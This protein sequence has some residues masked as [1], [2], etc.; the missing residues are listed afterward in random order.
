MPVEL[1]SFDVIIGMDWLAKYHAVIVCAE[2]IVISLLETKYLIV[3]RMSPILQ[4]SSATKD[5]DKSKEKRLEDVLVV[6]EFPEIFPEDLSARAPYRLAPSEMKETIARATTWKLYG[7]RL[8]QTNPTPCELR[9]DWAINKKAAFKTVEGRSC[10]VHQTC[11]LPEGN[12]SFIAYCDASKK[13]LGAVL[14]QKGKKSS[15]A[16]KIGD[17]CTGTKCNGGSTDHKSLQHILDQ[18]ELNMR[19][20]RWKER[21]P[22]RVRAL[23]MTI[24]LDLPKQILKAQQEHE[25]H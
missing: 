1:G 20:R 24:G 18:K 12:E 14:M 16:L 22:L 23:V 11:A 2:K 10:V 15:V 3:R 21:E 7:Q 8:H 9:Y 25:I 19:Q 17:I 13:G 6:Q 5:E 4:I